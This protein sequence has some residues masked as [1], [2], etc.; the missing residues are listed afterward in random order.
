MAQR[1]TAAEYAAASKTDDVLEA[2]DPEL[3]LLPVTLSTDGCR[4]ANWATPMGQIT[5]VLEEMRVE[6]PHLNPA[7]REAIPP[8]IEALWLLS[9]GK[10]QL[11]ISEEG[12]L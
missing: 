1:A 2:P 10:A 5:R 3:I 9:E 8:L 7:G 6:S 11:A 12:S 4:A